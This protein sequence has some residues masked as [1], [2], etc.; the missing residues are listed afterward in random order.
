MKLKLITKS[1]HPIGT[2]GELTHKGETLCVTVERAWLNN[3]KNKSCI[4]AGT[5]TVKKHDSPK[6]GKCFVLDNPNVGVTPSGN[7][8]RTHCLIHA[9]N[10]PNQLEG[11][12]AP[13]LTFH[14]S[15]WGVANSRDALDKLLAL[16]PDECELEIIRL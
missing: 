7:S 4:P 9:A 15:K 13:G 6:F 10:W 2:F 1:L 14:P 8:Q 12:I 5:Y 11:C 3:A 16:L